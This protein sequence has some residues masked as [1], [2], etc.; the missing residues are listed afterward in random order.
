MMCQIDGTG[1]TSALAALSGRAPGNDSYANNGR[2]RSA[3][4]LFVKK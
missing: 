4:E 1:A 2:E 3:R